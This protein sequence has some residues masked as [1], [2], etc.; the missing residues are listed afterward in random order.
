MFKD[1]SLLGTFPIPPL[2]GY[3]SSTPLD[4]VSS[5]QAST[6]ASLGVSP[7]SLLVTPPLVL[8]V[9]DPWVFPD[10]LSVDF[11][12]DSM[13]LIAVELEYQAIQMASEDA[14]LLR[15]IEGAFD[16]YTSPSQAITP[17]LSGDFLDSVLP[18][19]EAILETMVGFNQHWEE[20][21]HH[22]SFL[23]H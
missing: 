6:S 10:P 16:P 2:I 4:S 13:P 21:H 23:P 12:A 20:M 8:G 9:S 18:S 15:P 19:D 14:N 3:I 1:S 22:L 5:D 11:L 7:P 17:S